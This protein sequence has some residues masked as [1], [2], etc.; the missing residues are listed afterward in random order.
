MLLRI[1]VS[2][3]EMPNIQLQFRRDYAA[4]WASI[5]PV[6]ASGETGIEIDS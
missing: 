1:S 3:V 6:L 4:T 2:L 5:N